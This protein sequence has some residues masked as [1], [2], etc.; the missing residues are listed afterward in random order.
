MRSKRRRIATALFAATL[1]ASSVLPTGAPPIAQTDVRIDI[2]QT[3][4]P[5]LRVALPPSTEDRFGAGDRAIL[6]SARTVL[7]NDLT[8]SDLID[9][10]PAAGDSTQV[11]VA[12]T[13][14]SSAAGVE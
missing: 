8:L 11:E 12:T 3:G 14:S 2:S 9:V 10:E 1:L 7:A 13:V 5:K 6:E 4:A